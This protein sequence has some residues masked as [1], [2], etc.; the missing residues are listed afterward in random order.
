MCLVDD[1]DEVN[2]KTNPFSSEVYGLQKVHDFQKL[3]SD[4]DCRI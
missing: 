3:E 4:L 1:V 2:K